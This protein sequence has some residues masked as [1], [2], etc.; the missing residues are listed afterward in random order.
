[1]SSYVNENLTCVFLPSAGTL[2]FTGNPGFNPAYVKAITDQ[3]QNAFIYLPGVAGFGGTWDAT[4]TILTLAANV[5]SYG[6]SDILIVQY[7]DQ[8]NALTN[9]ANQVANSNQAQRLNSLL[10]MQQLASQQAQGGCGF[11]PVETPS[12]LTGV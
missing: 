3:T 4:G 2:V 6:A 7:D 1:M 8:G 11:V 10:F 12:F 9:I 5:S